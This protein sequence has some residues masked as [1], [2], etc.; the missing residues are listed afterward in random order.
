MK[1][2][3]VL[4][5]AL[6]AAAS[7]YAAD[8]PPSADDLKQALEKRLVTLK[9]GGS[10]ERQVLF[11]DVKP[12]AQSNGGYT[13]QVTASIRDYGPGYPKN[14]F[15]GETCVGRID[16]LPFVLRRDAYGGWQVEGRMT[17]DKR[18]CKRNPSE[19]VSSIP[20]ASLKGSAAPAAPQAASAKAPQQQGR[21]KL[22]PGRYECWNFTSPRLTLAFTLEDG[23]RYKDYENK[24]GSYAYDAA[25]GKLSFKGA[26]LDGQSPVYD[27]PGGRP[28]VSYRN[29]QGNEIAFCEL[30]S[31]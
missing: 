15:Y 13:F 10:T 23:G 4:C 7:S 27:T 16:N 25:S 14:K 21:G 20:L 26:A 11:E 8:R 9:P 18:E 24:S 1:L 28:K 22:M 19:G 31:R 6:C 5:A 17:P 2:P 12:G 29:A 30:A 3:V